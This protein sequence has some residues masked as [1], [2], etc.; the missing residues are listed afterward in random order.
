L[1]TEL[2]RLRKVYQV[3]EDT[4]PLSRA[5]REPRKNKKG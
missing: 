2:T 3:P 1:K 5:P 4:R